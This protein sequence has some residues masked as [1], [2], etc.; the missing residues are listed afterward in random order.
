MPIVCSS[1]N[2]GT[3]VDYVGEKRNSMEE[4]NVKIAMKIE[5][6]PQFWVALIFFID[7]CFFFF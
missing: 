2:N 4:R 6:L 7:F 3:G 5:E 1:V